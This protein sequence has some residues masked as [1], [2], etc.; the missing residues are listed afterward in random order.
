MPIYTRKGDQGQTSLFNKKR[1]WKNVQR[2]AAYGTI[3]ELNCILGIAAS[4]LAGQTRPFGKY[5]AKIINL[6]QNDFFFIGSYLANP[7]SSCDGISLGARVDFFEKEIDE[8]TKKLPELKNFIL[9]GGLYL[10]AVLQ[11]ARAVSRRAE[12]EI[13]ALFRQEKIDESILVYINRVS[14]LLFTMARFA[15]YFEKAKEVIWSPGL[16]A[17]GEK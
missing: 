5:L 17:T 4:H 8:M 1:V 6:L 14:D 7:K 12:R 10:G 2:V 16:K 9:P 15:N 3:D 13:V 11:L